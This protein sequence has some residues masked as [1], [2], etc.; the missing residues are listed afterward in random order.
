MCSIWLP[1]ARFNMKRLLAT[2][3]SASASGS[4]EQPGSLSE[5]KASPE[6]P[7]SLSGPTPVGSD[8]HPAIKRT[9]QVNDDLSIPFPRRFKK[10]ATDEEKRC[11]ETRQELTTLHRAMP[12][13]RWRLVTVG[14][15]DIYNDMYCTGIFPNTTIDWIQSAVG[16]LVDWPLSFVELRAGGRSFQWRRLIR[17]RDKTP[18]E[19]LDVDAPEVVITVVKKPPP[20]DFT[21]FPGLCL[22]DFGDCC[23]LA[24]NR[25]ENGDARKNYGTNGCCRSGGCDH[26]CCEVPWEEEAWQEV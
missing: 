3:A 25:D 24:A 11:P 5:S 2:S 15:A 9:K 13:R 26:D 14:G 23:L 6:Q 8:A 21:D 20:P 16:T 4:A 22:C 1:A 10:P 17:E 19:S 12:L 7:A 18:L